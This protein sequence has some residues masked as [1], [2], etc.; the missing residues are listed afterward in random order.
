MIHLKRFE[1]FNI[2]L[3]S[4]IDDILLPLGDINLVTSYQMQSDGKLVMYISPKYYNNKYFYLSS[5]RYEINHLISQ[6]EDY[7]YQLYRARFRPIRRFW[8]KLYDT[9]LNKWGVP[10]PKDDIFTNIEGIDI[11][12]EEVESF[13]II[14]KINPDVGKKSLL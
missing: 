10:M 6:L 9:Y 5:I 13:E 14:F 3:S 11:D 2:E 8:L 1:S 7:G 4:I 12:K